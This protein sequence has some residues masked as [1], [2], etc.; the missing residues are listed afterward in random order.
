[1]ESHEGTVHPVDNGRLNGDPISPTSHRLVARELGL[2]KG[3]QITP[4]AP[5]RVELT[6]EDCRRLTAADASPGWLTLKAAT[7][8]LDGV[9][10]ALAVH[11]DGSVL[12]GGSNGRLK[13]VP[14][15]N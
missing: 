10:Y 9:A 6:E 14:A 1:M 4:G 12:V 13:I 8:A 11:S 7:Q 15:R 2:L 3:L 5:W